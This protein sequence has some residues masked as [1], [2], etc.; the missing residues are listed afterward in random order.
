MAILKIKMSPNEL[1]D[2]IIIMNIINSTKKNTK[3]RI[4]VRVQFIETDVY[5]LKVILFYN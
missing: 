5:Q 2:H 3:Y 4:Y 1:I